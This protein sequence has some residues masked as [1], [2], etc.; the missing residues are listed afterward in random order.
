MAAFLIIRGSLSGIIFAIFGPPTISGD[1]DRWRSNRTGNRIGYCRAHSFFRIAQIARRKEYYDSA[2]RI[3][4]ARLLVD[5]C[6]PGIVFLD[7]CPIQSI[8]FAWN[9]S[10]GYIQRVCIPIQGINFDVAFRIFFS[11][12]EILR[13][14]VVFLNAV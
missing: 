6:F 3:R 1:T 12:S 2:L 8:D 11:L 9:V 14:Y 7:L 5:K 10:S 4:A 13:E